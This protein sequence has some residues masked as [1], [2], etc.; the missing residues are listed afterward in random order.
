M[1]YMPDNE[2]RRYKWADCLH[3][4]VP[5]KQFKAEVK[6]GKHTDLKHTIE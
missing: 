1:V 6:A 5:F 2:K 4:G 3:L